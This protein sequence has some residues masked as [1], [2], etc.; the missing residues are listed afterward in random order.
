M[1]LN[2]VTLFSTAPERVRWPT[3]RESQRST[4]VLTKERSVHS[5][6]PISLTFLI[7]LTSVEARGVGASAGGC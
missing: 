5:R 4:V 3:N 7:R 2:P 6:T 1:V